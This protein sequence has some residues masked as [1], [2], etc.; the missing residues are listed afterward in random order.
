L[1]LTLGDVEPALELVPLPPPPPSDVSAST[2]A[3]MPTTTPPTIN[4]VTRPG[5]RPAR[6]PASTEGL[7]RRM[8]ATAPPAARVEGMGAD[9][10]ALLLSPGAAAA[11]RR[12]PFTG[13]SVGAGGRLG[14]GE[15]ARGGVLVAP[16]AAPAAVAAAAVA[17]RGDEAPT[18]GPAVDGA[19]ASAGDARGV[20]RAAV[21][22]LAEAAAAV[23]G[24]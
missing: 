2:S 21:A 3:T 18:G 10:R 11:V 13:A 20:V 17:G 5:E 15:A 6:G 7:E 14:G 16:P 1:W 23:A 8:P 9:R 22:V 24:G 12:G 4:A 19:E